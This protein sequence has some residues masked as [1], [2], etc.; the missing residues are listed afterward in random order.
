MES[1]RIRLIAVDAT[2]DK[3][4]SGGAYQAVYFTELNLT[5]LRL[6]HNGVRMEAR[7]RVSEAPRRVNLS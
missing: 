6:P 3:L 7:I 5:L 2:S 1:E 4:G